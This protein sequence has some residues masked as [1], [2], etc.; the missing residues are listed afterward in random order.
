PLAGCCSLIGRL[1]GLWSRCLAWQL[2]LLTQV[3]GHYMD[4]LVETMHLRGQTGRLEPRAI[5]PPL[6]SRSDIFSTRLR[7]CGQA[8]SPVKRYQARTAGPAPMRSELTL[9]MLDA[10]RCVGQDRTTSTSLL[11]N[12]SLLVSQRTSSSAPSS[13]I[14]SIT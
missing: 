9:A 4:C 7:L 3:R 8:Y 1:R 14:S 13:S 12:A 2:T 10:T 11:S 6:M 5:P